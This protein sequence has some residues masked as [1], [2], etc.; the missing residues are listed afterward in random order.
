MARLEN[1]I[2]SKMTQT[3][4]KYTDENP[5]YNRLQNHESVRHSVGE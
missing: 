2:E 1:F 4:K 3:T 5:S